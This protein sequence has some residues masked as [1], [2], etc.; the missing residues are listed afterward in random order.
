MKGKDLQGKFSLFDGLAK[1]RY[2]T[3]KH[4]NKNKIE[5]NK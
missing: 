3:N 1:D 5:D 4:R 2:K